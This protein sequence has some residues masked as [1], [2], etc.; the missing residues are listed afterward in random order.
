MLRNPRD[1]RHRMTGPMSNSKEKAYSHG[2]VGEE[3]E[4][5]LAR[6]SNNRHAVSCRAG[7]ESQCFDDVVNSSSHKLLYLNGSSLQEA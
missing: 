4:I 6:A 2:G 7:I 5:L 1:A 3:R